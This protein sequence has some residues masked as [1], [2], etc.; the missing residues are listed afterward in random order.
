M[1][2]MHASPTADYAFRHARMWS[3]IRSSWAATMLLT[4]IVA[5]VVFRSSL[6][7]LLLPLVLTIFAR[8]LLRHYGERISLL[9]Y[10]L[11][12][13]HGIFSTHTITF[14]LWRVH[15]ELDQS[16]LGC[17]FDYG[18]IR[19]LSEG[20]W[21]RCDGIGRFSLLQ[22]EIRYRQSEL[23]MPSQILIQQVDQVSS[24]LRRIK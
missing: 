2:T 10:S 17:R 8:Q 20:R 4:A 11:G 18:S 3:L 6:P 22:A 12:I 24:A 7:L 21:Y 15:L 16:F 1:I 23:T 13:S 9:G 14:P 19:I 5:V